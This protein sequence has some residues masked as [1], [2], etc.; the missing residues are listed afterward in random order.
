MQNESPPLLSFPCVSYKL[1]KSPNFQ[2]GPESILRISLISSLWDGASPNLPLAHRPVI[3]PNCKISIISST[4]S[5]PTGGTKLIDQ[6]YEH[7][8]SKSFNIP[9][10]ERS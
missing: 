5:K 6:I 9:E 8:S 3:P 4:T 2:P 7:P 1:S 10:N